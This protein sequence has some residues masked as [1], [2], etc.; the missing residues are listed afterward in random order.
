MSRWVSKE[1]FKALQI[2]TTSFNRAFPQPYIWVQ[3]NEKLE[4]KSFLP[5]TQRQYRSLVFNGYIFSSVD[6]KI[7]RFQKQ[8]KCAYQN[9][10]RIFYNV[11]RFIYDIK[12]YE[13]CY[14][15]FDPKENKSNNHPYIPEYNIESLMN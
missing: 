10:K 14:K 2:Y 11:K 7:S 1:E 6:D 3:M 4:L 9:D 5:S 12:W 8:I 15:W 13:W